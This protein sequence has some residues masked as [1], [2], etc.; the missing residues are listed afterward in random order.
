MAENSQR[1]LVFCNQVNLNVFSSKTP[2]LWSLNMFKSPIH[3]VYAGVCDF[4]F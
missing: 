3:V 2:G 4:P 1:L